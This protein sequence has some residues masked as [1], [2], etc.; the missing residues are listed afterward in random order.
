MNL[1]ISKLINYLDFL[2]FLSFYFLNIS[3]VIFNLFWNLNLRNIIL[4]F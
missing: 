2:N 1:I 4:L 3:N